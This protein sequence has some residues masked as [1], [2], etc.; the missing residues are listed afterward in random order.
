VAAVRGGPGTPDPASSDV[1]AS[2][3]E[4]AEIA[5]LDLGGYLAPSLGRDG[6]GPGER[7]NLAYDI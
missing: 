1:L 7:H 3:R 5:G 6:I 2:L 4:S